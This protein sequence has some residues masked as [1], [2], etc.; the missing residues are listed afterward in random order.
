MRHETF[1]K[2]N[3]RPLPSPNWQYYATATVTCV[4]LVAGFFLA[5]RQHFSSMEYGLQNSRLRRQVDELESEKR[6]LMVSREVS[7]SP[8][9]LRK[10]VR[11]IGFMDAPPPQMDSYTSHDRIAERTI[12]NTVDSKRS[13]VE[14]PANKVLKTVI[15]TPVVKA[16]AMDKQARREMP[17]VK[18]DRT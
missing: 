7:L 8:V 16:P 4:I 6:K 13:D 2:R 17:T 11:R 3:A 10:A 18:K 15:N 5:A 14:K 9:E 1:P 12:I